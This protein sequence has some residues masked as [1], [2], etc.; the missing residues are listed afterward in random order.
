MQ[1]KKVKTEQDWKEF[2]KD[3][4]HLNNGT[5]GWFPDSKYHLHYFENVNK[6]YNTGEEWR[7]G[8]PFWYNQKGRW[9]ERFGIWFS[10][11]IKNSVSV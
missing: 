7:I 2:L 5:T 9:S 6:I 3:Q 10:N 4:T 1:L 11:F 8:N